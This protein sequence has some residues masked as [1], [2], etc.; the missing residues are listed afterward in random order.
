MASKGQE[1]PETA[2]FEV[3]YK[4]LEETVAR[5][6]KGNLTLEESITLY[7]DGMGLARRAQELLAEAQLRISRL[8]DSFGSGLS[9]REHTEDYAPAAIADEPAPE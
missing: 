7:E 8:Q 3:L 1:N 2:S 4:R 9:A 5:L 6:E